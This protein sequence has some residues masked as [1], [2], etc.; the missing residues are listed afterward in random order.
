GRKSPRAM[1]SVARIGIW[2]G[3]LEM[4]PAAGVPVST[5]FRA[6]LTPKAPGD[7][8]ACAGQNDPF[9][10]DCFGADPVVS[11]LSAIGSGAAHWLSVGRQS[12]LVPA[13]PPD[14]EASPDR[15]PPLQ[16]L[17][18]QRGHGVSAPKLC[19]VR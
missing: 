4:P 2:C 5:I 10:C 1:Q 12:T 13:E 16:T 9:A 3:V 19:A 11:G 15:L 14:P 6:G 7:N 18:M 17:L 8:P